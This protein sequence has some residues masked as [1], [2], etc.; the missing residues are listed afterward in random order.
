MAT[1]S[2]APVP[3]PPERPGLWQVPAFVVGVGALVAVCLCRPLWT[4]RPERRVDR[5]LAAARHLL[6]RADGDAEQALRLATRARD[7][8]EQVP[9]RAGEAALLLGSAHL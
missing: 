1:P 6:A 3:P 9:D 8:A 5:D 7:A 2:P 4:D